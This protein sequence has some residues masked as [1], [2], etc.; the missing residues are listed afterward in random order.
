MLDPMI[1]RTIVAFRRPTCGLLTTPAHVAQ[2]PPDMPRVIDSSGPLS[3]HVGHPLESPDVGAESAG[4][5]S[6][7]EDGLD[8][9]E[10]VVADLGEAAGPRRDLQRLRAAL[11]PAVEPDAGSLSADA[12]F[13]GDVRWPKSLLEQLG[14]S[15][16]AFLQGSQLLWGAPRTTGVMSVGGNSSRRD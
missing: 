5:R 4:A 14:S 9:S 2:Q 13:P 7:E 16:S 3:D 12:Q 15:L 1:D 8:G 11:R 6:L 10:L